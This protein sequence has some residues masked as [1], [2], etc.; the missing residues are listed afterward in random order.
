[1]AQ[2]I[3]KKETAAWDLGKVT[4][5]GTQS[6]QGKGAFEDGLRLLSKQGIH[7]LYSIYGMTQAGG[8]RSQITRSKSFS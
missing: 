8:S 4:Q 1:V 5:A 2:L 7:N 6:N 3:G